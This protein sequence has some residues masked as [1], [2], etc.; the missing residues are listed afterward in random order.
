VEAIKLMPVM[1]MAFFVDVSEYARNLWSLIGFGLGVTI[2]DL[3]KI[4]FSDIYVSNDFYIDYYIL[5]MGDGT[6]TLRRY[7]EQI[8]TFKF[9]FHGC[10]CKRI[11]IMIWYAR[12]ICSRRVA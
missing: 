10:R 11:L 6:F 8:I 12:N 4:F 7:K 9:V 2:G 3:N 1:T 5:I